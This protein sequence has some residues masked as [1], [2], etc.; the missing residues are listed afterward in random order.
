MKRCRLVSLLKFTTFLA[1]Y[2]HVVI[3]C[4]LSFQVFRGSVLY[5]SACVNMLMQIQVQTGGTK[6]CFHE[7]AWECWGLKNYILRKIPK[8][9][10]M[11]F[12][13]L[14]ENDKGEYVVSN[15]VRMADIC[16]VSLVY[17]L[18]Y[19]GTYCVPIAFLRQTNRF[20]YSIWATSK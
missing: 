3:T 10:F 9:S 6:E 1:P 20:D 7:S 13:L 11:N 2:E 5:K 17:F 8:K 14:Y 15:N 16:L 4:C 18:V 12:G 19:V